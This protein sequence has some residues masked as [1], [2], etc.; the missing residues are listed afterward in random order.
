MRNPRS[1]AEELERDPVP[2]EGEG[3][4]FAGYGVMGLPFSTGHLLAFRRMPASSVGP[5]YTTVW[6]RSPTRGWTFYT[7][8][9]PALSCPRYYGEALARVVVAEIE[10]GWEGPYDLFLRAPDLAF[11]WGIR[12]SGD[13]HTRMLSAFGR[14]APRWVWRSRRLLSWLGPLGGRVLGIGRLGL[15]GTVP[16]GQTFMAAPRL[17]WRVGASAAILDGEDLGP[18]HPLPQQAKLENLWIP[19]GGVFALGEARF[20]IPAE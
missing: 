17:L 9:D 20:S 15:T 4:R 13:S 6:H 19:N 18:I 16:C 2:P 12:L 8:V 14:L 11:Q 10:L 5:A 1:L 7:D 3:E